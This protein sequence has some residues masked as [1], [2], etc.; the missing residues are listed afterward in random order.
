MTVINHLKRN[1]I[2]TSIHYPPF[3][4][5]KAYNDSFKK[6][7]CPIEPAPPITKNDE[8][9]TSSDSSLPKAWRS[10]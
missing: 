8:S 7:D 6:S 10:I 9:D 1:G 2:Q 5:F 4:E 3:W